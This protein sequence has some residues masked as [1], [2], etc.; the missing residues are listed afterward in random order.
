MASAVVVLSSASADLAVWRLRVSVLWRCVHCGRHKCVALGVC[1]CAVSQCVIAALAAGDAGCSL[2]EAQTAERTLR[3]ADGS[4]VTARH[5]RPV[6]AA[7][8]ARL[9]LQAATLT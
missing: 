1:A 3:A 4:A 6:R 2:A 7:V 8:R 9:G 5:C